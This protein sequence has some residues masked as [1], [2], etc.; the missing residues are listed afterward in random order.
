[1]S[2]SLPHLLQEVHCHPRAD[3]MHNSQDVV[4]PDSRLKPCS[5]HHHFL[6]VPLKCRIPA[7]CAH[8]R[9]MI[10]IGDGLRIYVS[11]RMVGSSIPQKRMTQMTPSLQWKVSAKH[12]FPAC[13]SPCVTG[14][15]RVDLRDSQQPL[16]EFFAPVINNQKQKH[17][18]GF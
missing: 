16:A 17:T 7:A 12:A 8:H 5:P 4:R 1:M 18:H 15:S 6:E 9:Q 11:D 13:S 3:T 10:T 2:N 14:K